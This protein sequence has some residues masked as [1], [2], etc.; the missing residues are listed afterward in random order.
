M[1]S[2]ARAGSS[3]GDRLLAFALERYPFAATVVADAFRSAAGDRPTRT[4]DEIEALRPAFRA[5]L[6][7]ALRD[8]P[9]DDTLELT[10]RVGAL[11]DGDGASRRSS[12]SAMPPC[13]DRRS[14]TVSPR[15]SGA[16]SSAAC[17]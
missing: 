12:K 8:A 16:K 6:Y 13:G 17:C 11:I 15:T 4:S 3:V 10:P 14:F 9:R 5:A 1:G 7:N 2:G